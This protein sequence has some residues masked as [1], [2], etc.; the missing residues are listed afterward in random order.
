MVYVLV[1]AY[2]K[3]G[4]S[5]ESEDLVWYIPYYRGRNN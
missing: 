5:R 4:L 2:V 3:Q 1:W